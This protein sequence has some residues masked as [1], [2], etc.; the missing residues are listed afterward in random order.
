M[1]TL[2]LVM[3]GLLALDAICGVLLI[4]QQRKGTYT[5]GGALLTI[6]LDALVVLAI[7]H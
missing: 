3:I 5:A 1:E 2:K 7:I 4:G 6:A